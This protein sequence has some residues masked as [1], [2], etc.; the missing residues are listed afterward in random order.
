MPPITP[1]KFADRDLVFDPRAKLVYVPGGR[2]GRSKLLI[3]KQVGP[4]DTSGGRGKPRR[5][6][7]CSALGHSNFSFLSTLL[8]LRK[9]AVRGRKVPCTRIWAAAQRTMGERSWPKRH[10]VSIWLAAPLICGR[11]ICFHPGAVT[12]NFA[13]PIMTTCKITPQ[14]GKAIQICAQSI[15]N[16]KSDSAICRLFQS[17]KV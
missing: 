8:I 9:I 13:V 12:V 5:F 11:S 1:S 6:P 14:P 7:S 4:E 2:E 15:I 17:E 10:V 3:L 16:E